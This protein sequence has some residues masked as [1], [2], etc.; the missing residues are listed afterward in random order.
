MHHFSLK[1]SNVAY[2]DIIDTLPSFHPLAVVGGRGRTAC[3]AV[4]VGTR[5]ANII[6]IIAPLLLSSSLRMKGEK[7]DTVCV[8]CQL[9]LAY[10]VK[11]NHFIELQQV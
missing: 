6:L 5:A 9:S 7:E 11:V 2:A 3:A 1:D 8:G 10:G 4:V